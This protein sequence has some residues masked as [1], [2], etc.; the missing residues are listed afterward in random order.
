V[1]FFSW[2]WGIV[3]LDFGTSLWTGAPVIEELWIRSP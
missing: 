3:R 2:V 1:Q